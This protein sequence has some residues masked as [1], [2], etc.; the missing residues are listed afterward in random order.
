MIIIWRWW[1]FLGL[2][3]AGLMIWS[4]VEMRHSL[5]SG[6][7]PV[8]VTIEALQ[9]GDP[10]AQPYV[11]V[12]EHEALF[13]LGLEG[14]RKRKVDWVVYPVVD[15]NHRYVTAWR[16]LERRYPDPRRAPR[17]ALPQLDG[18][19]VFVLDKRPGSRGQV[20]LRPAPNL[21]AAAE[22]LLFRWDDL[23]RHETDALLAIQPQLD[24]SRAFVLE[25][26]RRPRPLW[27][28][29]VLATLGTIL[30]VVAIRLFRKGRAADR[31][32]ASKRR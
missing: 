2:G 21:V 26:A 18:A 28:C 5:A 4:N 1:Y 15:R 22:G 16:E 6:T 30:L 29:V 11:R 32:G 27:L 20:H 23:D 24:R 3:G 8:E 14:G 10:V 17:G 19:S 31:R 13:G 25:I 12:G 7:S 9:R